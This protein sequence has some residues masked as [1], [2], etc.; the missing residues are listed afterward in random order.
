MIFRRK[1]K[2]KKV[3]F[4]KQKINKSL[5]RTSISKATKSSMNW[6]LIKLA[7]QI[8]HLKS[9]STIWIAFKTKNW[10]LPI[11]RWNRSRDKFWPSQ[12]LWKGSLI[13]L[14][15]W[16]RISIDKYTKA[17]TIEI[18]SCKTIKSKWWNSNPN[19]NLVSL[20]WVHSWSQVSLQYQISRPA[21]SFLS[22]RVPKVKNHNHLSVWDTNRWRFNKSWINLNHQQ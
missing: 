14:R 9:T 1:K 8:V 13:I 20:A 15:T 7:I 5:R 3:K 18:L 17:V 11:L 19:Q 2:Y 16:N 22:V 6:C 12:I 21:R 10:S 4:R